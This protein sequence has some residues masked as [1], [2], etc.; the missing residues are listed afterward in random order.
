VRG[1]IKVVELVVCT[2]TMEL[3]SFVPIIMRNS[4]GYHCVTIS[5]I[6]SRILL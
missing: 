5:I 3:A 4:I 1:E 2:G 6:C